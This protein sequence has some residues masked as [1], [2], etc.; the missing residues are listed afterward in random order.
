MLR[1]GATISGNY[2]KTE[3]SQNTTC[4]PKN[5]ESID[6][7]KYPTLK[8]NNKRFGE[9]INFDHRFPADLGNATPKTKSM[10]IPNQSPS[11]PIENNYSVHLNDKVSAKIP[12]EVPS[13][14]NFQENEVKIEVPAGKP[15][16]ASAPTETTEILTTQP[17]IIDS[18]RNFS[19]APL[20]K[21]YRT[22]KKL[23]RMPKYI[24]YNAKSKSGH[25]FDVGTQEWAT[26]QFSNRNFTRITTSIP[27]LK[28]VF[29]SIQRN[30]SYPAE[31]VLQ[32]FN[33]PGLRKEHAQSTI[34]TMAD[35]KCI[36]Y[37][38]CIVI[39]CTI[40]VLPPLTESKHPCGA[41][42]QQICIS[43]RSPINGTNLN[44]Y[45]MAISSAICFTV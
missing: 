31:T 1:T 39:M 17:G 36:R 44:F 18:S 30:C 24:R 21:N 3:N 32:G 9:K 20:L 45:T 37:K 5:Q 25:N 33:V 27:N 22:R 14:V 6:T 10:E 26:E 34:N 7:T 43:T 8:F 23:F 28:P 42:N 38:P 19:Y 4:T 2:A 41:E 29:S 15:Y 16:T 40:F 12:Y 35:G 13:A 11:N